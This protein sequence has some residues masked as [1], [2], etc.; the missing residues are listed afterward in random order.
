[1]LTCSVRLVFLLIIILLFKRHQVAVAEGSGIS[2]V[3]LI[4]TLIH[5]NCGVHG[6]STRTNASA[7]PVASRPWRLVLLQLDRLIP[8]G[9][10]RWLCISTS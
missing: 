8:V 1:M 3:R 9:P 6:W 7:C 4:A 10:M 5:I 2:F